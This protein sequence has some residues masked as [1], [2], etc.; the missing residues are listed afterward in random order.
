MIIYP[1]LLLSLLPPLILIVLYN[2][3]LRTLVVFEVLPLS[4]H[5]YLT[6][7]TFVPHAI[8]TS[9]C[10]ARLC[11]IPLLHNKRPAQLKRPFENVSLRPDLAPF[12]RPSAEKLSWRRFD[13]YTCKLCN[14]HSL[15]L[16][17]TSAT[18]CPML[19]PV[20]G[21]MSR[22][23]DDKTSDTFW[24]FGNFKNKCLMCR[25]HILHSYV[26]QYIKTLKF[27]LL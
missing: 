4:F 24:T 18:T 1:Y 12:S 20:F 26:I 10:S 3:A 7:P 9:S 11:S 16:L 25:H 27:V 21:C 8:P 22:Q 15:W 17:A 14:T 19:I 2:C 5:Y 23:S 13:I 6:P